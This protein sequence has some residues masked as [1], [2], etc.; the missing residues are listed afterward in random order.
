M[1]NISLFTIGIYSAI[2][3]S[4]VIY[5]CKSNRCLYMR[6]QILPVV[7]KQSWIISLTYKQC[8]QSSVIASF[9][10][11]TII[12]W[13]Y[14]RE[15]FSNPDLFTYFTSCLYY[16]NTTWKSDCDFKLWIEVFV[17]SL[18]VLFQQDMY[19]GSISS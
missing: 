5:V 12:L 2:Y 7:G 15:E 17:F 10:C 6:L 3:I 16:I 11:V 14:H 8:E 18:F 13:N 1:E 4:G 9:V 19:T